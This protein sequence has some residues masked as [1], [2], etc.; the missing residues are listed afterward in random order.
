MKRKLE[1]NLDKRIKLLSG[2]KEDFTISIEDTIVLLRNTLKSNKILIYGNG[3][4]A[5]QSSHFAAELV[6]RFYKDRPPI[7]AISLTTDTA[8]LTSIANDFSYNSMLNL[9]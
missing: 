6:N 3:G 1:I 8:N 5:T 7:N 2:L 9:Y 4:S